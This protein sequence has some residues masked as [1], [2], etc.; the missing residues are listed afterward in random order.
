MEKERKTKK[1][2]LKLKLMV[3]ILV[4]A[5][6]ALITDGLNYRTITSLYTKSNEVSDSKVRDLTY[7]AM[8][9]KSVESAQKNLYLVL[10]TE[11]AS[12]KEAMQNDFE[13]LNTTFET[14]ISASEASGLAGQDLDNLKSFYALVQSYETS[15]QEMIASGNAATADLSQLKEDADMIST[16]LSEMSAYQQS[17][18]GA[19]KTA[20]DKSFHNAIYVLVGMLIF[21]LLASIICWFV[22]S[23]TIVNPTTRATQKLKEIIESIHL[24]KGDLTERIVVETNDEIGMMLTSVNT[25]IDTLQ[26]IIKDIQDETIE[27]EGA[28]E[29]VVGETEN[30]ARNVTD[31][32]ATMEELAASM[33][34][35]SASIENI[36]E[37]SS[38]VKDKSSEM[39]NEAV[40]GFEFATEMSERANQLK[41][42]A[43]RSQELTTQMIAEIK[44]TLKQAIDNSRKVDEINSLTTDILNISSQTNLLA[45]NASIEAARA[46]EAGKGFA[47]V[48]EE[49]RMLADNSRDTANNI[50]KLSQMVNDAVSELSGNAGK[51]IDFMDSNVLDDYKKLVDTGDQYQEDSTRVHDMMQGI[52]NNANDMNHT[53]QTMADAISD[54]TTTV[55][56]SANAVST[57]AENTTALV[58][59]VESIKDEMENNEQIANK[60]KIEVD[61]FEKI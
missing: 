14:F 59:S 35:V 56:E 20:Q 52:S 24:E 13:T 39:N 21:I 42:A 55:S 53:M 47:V 17:D 18:I 36:N 2:S 19:A 1:I 32:S 33:Q 49:I 29:K 43:I 10:L 12:A 30:S 27:L 45:L 5:A 11:D 34:E 41:S 8:I 58:T 46:G 61:K 38:R 51:M 4:L 28:V 50:Q 48:A 22:I 23:I 40:S 57:V 26:R 6:A 60:L 9:S 25:F 44:T 16:N 15:A 37:S 3:L 7:V 31:I 54:M